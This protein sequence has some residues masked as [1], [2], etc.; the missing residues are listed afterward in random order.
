MA[1]ART[2]KPTIAAEKAKAAADAK[3][4]IARNR[5]ARYDYSIDAAY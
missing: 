3:Q 5:R 4:V 1:K 2:G